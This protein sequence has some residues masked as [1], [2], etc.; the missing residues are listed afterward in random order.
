M[1]YSP[2]FFPGSLT[3]R[4]AD[5][6]PMKSLISI[7]VQAISGTTK[8]HRVHG[9]RLTIHTHGVSLPEI[10]H[11]ARQRPVLQST[12]RGQGLCL[13]LHTVSGI[14]C[15]S[16]PLWRRSLSCSLLVEGRGSYEGRDE[17]VRA[18]L[19]LPCG[20]LQAA[21]S[22][23]QGRAGRPSVLGL[24]PHRAPPHAGRG[25]AL[26]CAT[27][28]GAPLPHEARASWARP[29]VVEAA[30]PREA[31]G[32]VAEAGPVDPVQPPAAGEAGGVPARAAAPRLG[33]AS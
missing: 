18:V 11:P 2:D 20:I 15:V 24:L 21:G 28:P 14:L 13:E 29:G 25:L 8:A 5:G 4:I 31:A 6:L 12:V 27:A 19:A 26:V 9:W 23:L 10:L 7:R 16:R 30:V 33:A 3:S 1:V 32:L 17:G 22:L